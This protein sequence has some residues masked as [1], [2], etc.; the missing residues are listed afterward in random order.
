MSVYFVKQDDF[1]KIGYATDFDKRLSSL[2]TASP[3]TL[4]ALALIPGYKDVEKFFHDKFKHLK[5][6]GEWYKIDDSL[7]ECIKM[8]NVL[9]KDYKE[10]K[11][12]LE[13]I[14]NE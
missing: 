7:M 1:V 12:E 5:H 2:Q 13:W 4:E 3:H 10:V 14:D 9:Y 11:S 6:R 8:L